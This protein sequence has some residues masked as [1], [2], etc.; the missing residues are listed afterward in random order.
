MNYVLTGTVVSR[1][2][3]FHVGGGGIEERG[4]KRRQWLCIM[5]TLRSTAAV[6]Q[7]HLKI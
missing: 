5:G 2:F 6:G 7:P 4:R 1:M 3:L